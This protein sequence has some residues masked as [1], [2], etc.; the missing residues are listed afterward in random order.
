M[1][2]FLRFNL[3]R[4][5]LPAVVGALGIWATIGYA[6]NLAIAQPAKDQKKAPSPKDAKK[7]PPAKNAKA[8]PAAPTGS[9]IT[10]AT[11]VEDVPKPPKTAAYELRWAGI[12][13]LHAEAVAAEK[14]VVPGQAVIKLTAVPTTGPHHLIAQFS[15]MRSGSICRATIWVKAQ[16][17]ERAVV[18]MNNL[19]TQGYGAVFFDLKGGTVIREDGKLPAKTITSAPNGWRKLA[20]ELSC[21]KATEVAVGIGLVNPDNS[22][23]FSGDGRLQLLF[24]GAELE[25]RG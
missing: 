22:S 23:N 24:G 21:L 25:V 15:G 17:G 14:S 1:A 6:P 7:A 4:V 8:A 2:S 16:S 10:K 20:V 12:E 11:P 18:G 3:T 5:L 19:A 13:G 9:P